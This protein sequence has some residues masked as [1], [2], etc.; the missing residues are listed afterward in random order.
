MCEA[1][2]NSLIETEG[3]AEATGLVE[4]EVGSLVGA[5]CGRGTVQ[6]YIGKAYTFTARVLED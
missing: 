1:S 5:V 2:L 4:Y 3:E 6:G